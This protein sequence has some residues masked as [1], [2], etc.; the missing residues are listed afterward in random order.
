MD[1]EKVEQLRFKATELFA[2]LGGS[3]NKDAR[4]VSAMISI[5]DTEILSFKESPFFNKLTKALFDAEKTPQYILLGKQERFLLFTLPHLKS[6]VSW[7]Y[8]FS[9]YY[10][11][12]T[13]VIF[14]N[15]INF[16]E[17]I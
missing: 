5:V 13:E 2:R 4:I 8:D 14:T 10:I 1:I 6:L 12:D 7:S 9:N 17:V 16:F 3:G 15:K 11:G